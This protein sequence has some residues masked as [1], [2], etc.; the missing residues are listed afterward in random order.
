MSRANPPDDSRTAAKAL[1]AI[2]VRSATAPAVSDCGGAE[3]FALRVIGGDMLPE[4]ADGDIIIVEPEGVAAPGSFVVAQ[5]G[6]E[7][8]FRQLQRDPGGWLL[9]ALDATL[10]AVRLEGLDAV[11]GVV[12]QKAKP[13]RRRSTKRYVD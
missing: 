13:G 6:G 11:R 3:A 1:A 4:F 9:V 5:S 7:W 12:I 8:Y 10:P 2:G